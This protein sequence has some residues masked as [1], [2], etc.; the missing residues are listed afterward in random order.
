MKTFAGHRAT[1][2][3]TGASPLLPEYH[4]TIGTG[5]VL[6]SHEAGRTAEQL[7][8]S[9]ASTQL[10]SILQMQADGGDSRD[11][12]EDGSRAVDLVLALFGSQCLGLDT[13]R[14]SK[15]H[16][17]GGGGTCRRRTFTGI[18]LGKG[19][20]GNLTCLNK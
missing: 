5:P 12:S 19:G 9:D 4:G 17:G 1:L 11:G 14:T 15:T 18:S 6:I 16:G 3:S 10:R 8:G 7:S 13:C 20:F 2:A